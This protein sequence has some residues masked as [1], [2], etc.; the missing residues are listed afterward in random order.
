MPV[1]GIDVSHHNGEVDWFAVAGSEVR[2]GYAKATDGHSFV[3]PQFGR[4]WAQMREAGLLRGAYHFARPGEDPEVQAVHFVSVVGTPSWE[5]L[6]PALD[7]EVDGRRSGPDI[8]EWTVAFLQRAE[9]LLGRSFAM[10]TGGL[11]RRRLAPLAPATFGTRLLWTA[12]YGSAEP[13]VPAPW[14]RWDIWQ[15]TD[16]QSGRVQPI[17]GVRG[18][19]D[20]DRFRGELAELQALA[21]QPATPAPP[22]PPP[23]VVVDAQPPW[24][25]RFFVYPHQPTITGSDVRSWQTQMRDRGLVVTPDGI[26]GPESK[27][28]CV[29]F[30]RMAGLDPN[31]IVDRS[32]WEASFEASI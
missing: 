28:G 12:R 31:G 14:T 27:R 22:G 13:V 32:T 21:A 17:P 24:P 5:E 20:C 30:Q 2:F 4:N 3:D 10:Y 11:W 25:G 7:L 8:L 6:P 1:L 16:G 15:F 26:Y 23:P 19:V 9:A 29:A 18:L